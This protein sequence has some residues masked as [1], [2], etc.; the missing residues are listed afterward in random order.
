MNYF[1]ELPELAKQYVMRLLLLD[2]TVPLS[3]ITSWVN[4]AGQWYTILLDPYTTHDVT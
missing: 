2:G 3:V 1:R 4:T